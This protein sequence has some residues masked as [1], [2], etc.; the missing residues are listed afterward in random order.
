MVEGDKQDDDGVDEKGGIDKRWRHLSGEKKWEGL[1]DPLD[2]DLR[3]YIVHYGTM[4]EATYDAFIT[5]KASKYAGSC[6]YAKNDFFV[7]IRIDNRGNPFRY[8]VTKY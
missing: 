7:R 2:S 5:E 1:L 3:L 8:R 6:R 4:A